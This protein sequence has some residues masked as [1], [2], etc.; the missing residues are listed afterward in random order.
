MMRQLAAAELNLK[1]GSTGTHPIGGLPRAV[2][3][4]FGE[5]PPAY[6]PQ[7]VDYTQNGGLR[8][9]YS[10]W[11]WYPVTH[12]WSYNYFFMHVLPHI[13]GVVRKLSVLAGKV[14]RTFF[15]PFYYVRVT[16]HRRNAILCKRLER[17]SKPLSLFDQGKIHYGHEGCMVGSSPKSGIWNV[18]TALL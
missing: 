9:A 2:G 8:Y 5:I 4:T 7:P 16:A 14:H 17:I 1:L 11:A 6:R 13:L 18:G 10:P 15:S 12:V 3:D